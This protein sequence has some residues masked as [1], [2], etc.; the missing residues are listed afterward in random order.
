MRVTRVR[1]P[2]LWRFRTLGHA[3]GLSKADPR[4]GAHKR[5]PA[6]ASTQCLITRTCAWTSPGLCGTAGGPCSPQS[7]QGVNAFTMMYRRPCTEVGELIMAWPMM[8]FTDKY[9]LRENCGARRSSTSAGAYS[10]WSIS[11]HRCRTGDILY[12]HISGTCSGA[13]L[14]MVGGQS[15]LAE[16][17]LIATTI[18]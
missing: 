6:M 8:P 3:R 13:R 4:K 14:R 16:R 17:W 12:T 2:E 18:L 10:N 7:E 5:A 15:G 9:D 11:T 1:E